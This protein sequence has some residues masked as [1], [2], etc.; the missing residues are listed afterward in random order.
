MVPAFAVIRQMPGQSKFISFFG[1]RDMAHLTRAHEQLYRRGPDEQYPSLQTLLSRCVEDRER[2]CDRWELPQ[3]IRA[4]DDEHEL[5][6]RLNGDEATCGL[7]DWSFTQLCELSRV[8]KDTLNRL[9][10]G[11]ARLVFD[12]TFPS[13]NKPIQLY[14]EEGLIRSVHGT[15]YTRLHDADLVSMLIEFAVD[16][17]PP[18]EARGGGTGLYRGEQDLFCFLID[19]TGWADIGGQAFAPGFFVWNSEVGKR[20]VGISTFWFQAVCANHIVWDATEVVEFTR[21]H[22]GK[23]GEALGDIRRIVEGL[24]AKR[25]ERR[26]GFVDVVRRAM[27]ASLG[28]DEEEA[29]KLLAGKGIGKALGKKALETA[30]A[31]GNR[32][33]LFSVVDALTRLSGELEFAGERAAADGKASALLSL[34]V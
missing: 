31:S 3:D 14:T 6:L 13:G 15:H 1:D 12:E 30:R 18:Q 9:S 20:S 33:T 19:P 2:S 17:G 11:T 25:D 8:S 21:K 4:A 29:L 16:F 5:R 22:T 32:F 26:D 34:A 23:V 10:P 27:G 28:E 24:V 7:N